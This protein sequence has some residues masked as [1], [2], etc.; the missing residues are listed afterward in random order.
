MSWGAEDLSAALGASSKYDADGELTFTYRWR[1]RCAWPARSPPGSSRSTACSPTS[2]T[3]PGL[4]AEAARRGARRLHRQARHPPR[5]GRDRSTPP[6]RRR[7]PKSPTPQAIIAA[8]DAE[9]DAGVLSVGGRM[10]DRPHLIQAQGVL[11]R[12][13]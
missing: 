12:A 4:S 8:F 9:P 2:R 5:P 11:A 3:M 13:R 1:V 7:P 10:V 6:S